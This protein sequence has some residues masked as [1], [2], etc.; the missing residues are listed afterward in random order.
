MRI[1]K[2]AFLL[3][4]MGMLLFAR[5]TVAFELP[6]FSLDS[7]VEEEQNREVAAESEV[8]VST[9]AASES[10]SV[11]KPNLEPE[12]PMDFPE[13]TLE[14]QEGVDLGSMEEPRLEP[15]AVN[16]ESDEL[17]RDSLRR[18]E[19]ETPAMPRPQ[20]DLDMPPPTADLSTEPTIYTP[21][22]FMETEKADYVAP[23]RAKAT[24]TYSEGKAVV[25]SASYTVVEDQAETQVLTP[26]LI[27]RKT[28]KLR[29][30]NGLEAY[31]VSDP[32]VN[33]SGAALSV[34]V[35][36]W[37]DPKER[38]G[39]AHFIE[40]MLFLGNSKYPEE[41]GFTSFVKEHNGKR[42]AFTSNDHTTYGFSISHDGF[43]E[44]LERFV[45]QFIDPLFTSSGIDRELT[46]VDQEF[47]KSVENDSVRQHMIHK[48]IGNR[49]HPVTQFHY[50]NRETLE[51]V[52]QEQLKKWF[53][54]NYSANLMR[55]VVTSTLPLEELRDEVVTNFSQVRNTNAK[56]V[57]PQTTLTSPTYDGHMVYVTPLKEL[58]TLTLE[59]ELS[60]EF[61]HDKESKSMEI[62]SHVL[63]H[64]GE[65]S[66]LAQLKRE[67]LADALT[68]RSARMGPNNALIGLEIAL[69]EEG[70]KKVDTVI[71]RCFQAV[72]HLNNSGIPPYL[73]D[74]VQKMALLRYQ[75]QSR[76]DVFHSMMAQA[77][78]LIDENLETYPEQTRLFQKFNPRGI[79]RLFGELT[80]DHC[81]ITLMASAEETG[82]KTD[83]VEKWMGTEY[84]I[85]PVPDRKLTAWYNVHTH[86]NLDVPAP[87]PFIPD[88]LSI[89]NR[90]APSASQPQPITLLDDN[91]G[92]VYFAADTQY[93]V[94]EVSWSFR[95]RT[96]EVRSH[97]N[98]SVL[99]DLYLKS[100]TE[101]LNTASYKA[102]LAGLSYALSQ[103]DEALEISIAG[104]SDKADVLLQDIL[105]AL[106]NVSPTEEQF[107]VY[108]QTL[109]QSYENFSKESPL[110]QS[111]EVLNSVVF[112]EF[113]RAKE[114]AAAID[115]ISLDELQR[116]LVVVLEKAYVEALLYGNMTTTDAREVWNRV[117][118]TLA[119]GE[120]PLEQHRKQKVLVLPET[121]GPFYIVDTTERQGNA[122]LLMIQ[123][124]VFSF[125]NRAAQQILSQGLSEPFFTTLR[126]KQQTGYLVWNWDQEIERQLYSFFAV[127]SS[128][129]NVRDLLARFELFLETFLQ[130]FSNNEF[131]AKRFGLI[132]DALVSELR[133]PRKNLQ[134]M[135]Q[136]LEV[137][138]FDY[139]AD[140]DWIAKRIQG[141]E[142]LTY[143]EF[144][145]VAQNTMGRANKKRL[146]ILMKGSLQEENAFYYYRVNTPRKMR[147]ISAYVPRAY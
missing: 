70:I 51:G 64:E 105:H 81:H 71:E 76:E 24:S 121:V 11:T 41:S 13:V 33:R 36:S 113:V 5:T 42:N 97:V 28:M 75:Y 92:R 143:P 40:H 6:F 56:R 19:T 129:H 103:K 102:S 52:T 95:L 29:L 137:L 122:V 1:F 128:T 31:L 93:L 89:V 25:P 116:F 48:E 106:K 15:R 2:Y 67:R 90:P 138:A 66:I 4:M 60:T 141:F 50:G 58:R 146:A 14:V 124:G 96:P 142:E 22:L 63:G 80:P 69:T 126:T 27:K 99:T 117:N 86:E 45:W 114:K 132:K 18:A 17:A 47:A 39:M 145:D 9:T 59:W 26:S 127:Q 120:Y 88:S 140:F 3:T 53:A 125:K 84:A 131:P 87:N 68:S 94:P 119:S 46:A 115:G 37:N 83:R 79:R 34:A 78:Q 135:G 38:Q 8:E 133:Q 10:R 35:G 109:R 73:F 21:P 130:E 32:D 49:Y 44:G 82:V 55:L 20:E 12:M 139:D 136:L 101:M 144:L 62:V 104:L 134:E 112:D 123:Q 147:K 23:M 111:Q 74:E 30:D 98:S 16:M 65:E 57:A 7:E 110:A 108:K 91:S 54:D 61:A 100:V 85:Q 118:T 72:S 77:S 43:K 107:N